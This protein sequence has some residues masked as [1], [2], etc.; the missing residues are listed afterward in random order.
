MLQT[1][2]QEHEKMRQRAEGAEAILGSEK[3]AFDAVKARLKD[4]LNQA[5][6]AQ[7]EAEACEQEAIDHCQRVLKVFKSKT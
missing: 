3:V 5:L 1:A 4:D 2:Q 6:V 7:D